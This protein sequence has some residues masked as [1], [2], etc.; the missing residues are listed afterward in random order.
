MLA[1]DNA[2]QMVTAIQN[3]GRCS[4][5]QGCLFC[6]YDAARSGLEFSSAS[7]SFGATVGASNSAI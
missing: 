1:A 5:R 2:E 4:A 6:A 7:Q 3:P